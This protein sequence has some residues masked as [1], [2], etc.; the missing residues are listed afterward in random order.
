MPNTDTISHTTFAPNATDAT[1]ITVANGSRFRAGDAVRPN[2]AREVLMVLD[3]IGNVLTV[4]RRYGGSPGS[5][6]SN[7]QRLT[8]I[9]NATLEGDDAPP[10]RFTNRLRKR[11]FTQISRPA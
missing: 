6:L 8:I 1:A 4:S 10:A 7:G 5:V 3:V 2:G 9:G 11:N